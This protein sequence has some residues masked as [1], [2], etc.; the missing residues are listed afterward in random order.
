MLIDGGGCEQCDLTPRP[1]LHLRGEGQIV[2]RAVVESRG[3]IDAWCAMVVSRD[4]TDAWWA[5]LW[6]KRVGTGL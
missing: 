2:L 3:I 6:A 1:P 4:I 5:V